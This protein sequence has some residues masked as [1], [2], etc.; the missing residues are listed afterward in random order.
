[1]SVEILCTPKF[2]KQETAAL[3]AYAT[4]HG[5]SREEVIRKAVHDFSRRCVPTHS[6]KRVSR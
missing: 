5:M 3:D 2:T 1:M 6:R 4:S